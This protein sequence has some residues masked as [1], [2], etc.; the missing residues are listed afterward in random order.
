MQYA[1]ST[2]EQTESVNQM[3]DTGEPVFKRFRY[4]SNLGSMQEIKAG[5]QS[6]SQFAAHPSTGRN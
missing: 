3:D 5:Q 4:L 1:E 2:V 6:T